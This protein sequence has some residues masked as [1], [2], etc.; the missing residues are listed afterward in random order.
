MNRNLTINAHGIYDATGAVLADDEPITADEIESLLGIP[1][2]VTMLF[3][4]NGLVPAAHV[5]REWLSR[6]EPT[7]ND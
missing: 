3:N 6:Q 5:F 2:H 7:P 4:H 1:G